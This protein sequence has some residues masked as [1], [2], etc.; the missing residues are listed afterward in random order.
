METRRYKKLI[1]G[2]AALLLTA[3]SDTP[4]NQLRLNRNDSL[5]HI[6]IPKTTD[7][8][9]DSVFTEIGFIK[10]DTTEKALMG[11]PTDI[12]VYKNHI[13][14]LDT[15]TPS[16]LIFDIDGNFVNR[17]GRIG[18]GP[19]ELLSIKG[20]ELDYIRER[21]YIFDNYGFKC[22]VYDLYGNYIRT[23]PLGDP[24]GALGI[25]KEGNIVHESIRSTFGFDYNKMKQNENIKILDSLGNTIITGFNYNYNRNINAWF[26]NL[27]ESKS[28]EVTFAPIFRDT[29]YTVSEHDITPLFAFDFSNVK[30]L[31]KKMSDQYEDSNDMIS[32]EERGFTYLG[33]K[34]LNT[35]NILYTQLNFGIDRLHLFYNK[36]NGETQVVKPFLKKNS[37]L[38]PLYINDYDNGYFYCVFPH[39]QLE[40]LRQSDVKDGSSAKRILDQLADIDHNDNIIMYF[41]HKYDTP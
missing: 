16:V 17:A 11:D 37:E 34:H 40:M 12:R 8:S 32:D 4:D 23:I 41:K 18:R 3:C 38:F 14:T 33:G 13:Y 36:K 7:I 26:Y 1:L 15:H 22:G 29:I 20:I 5:H 25:T 24:C 35:P 2:I 10:L 30:H 21:L 6:T 19:Q 28:N 9:V 31:T 39:F 27:Y